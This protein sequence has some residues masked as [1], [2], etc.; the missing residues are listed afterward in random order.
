MTSEMDRAAKT[1]ETS[2]SSS[3][4]RNIVNSFRQQ[5]FEV[6]RAANE[7]TQ[8]GASPVPA[9][10][11]DRFREHHWTRLVS[12]FSEVESTVSRSASRSAQ[13]KIGSL[14]DGMNRIQTRLGL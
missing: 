5:L 13:E 11:F 14:R 2:L 6:Q 9:I 4:E 1:V 10:Y 7:L 3:F 12:Q 8:Y